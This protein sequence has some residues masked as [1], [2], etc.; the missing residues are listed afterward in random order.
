MIQHDKKVH[1]DNQKK[2]QINSNEI[3]S[4]V[5]KTGQYVEENNDQVAVNLQQEDSQK[6]IENFVEEALPKEID[7]EES[8]KLQATQAEA[9]NR[10]EAERNMPQSHVSISEAKMRLSTHGKTFGDSEKM[11]LVKNKTEALLSLLSEKVAT[12]VDDDEFEK[13]LDEVNQ[14]YDE[15]IVACQNYV[16]KA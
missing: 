16:K 1:V 3:Q 2:E 12:L 9:I 11:A 6:S 10:T 7:V 5:E 13:N 15:L 8:N 14:G 4:D